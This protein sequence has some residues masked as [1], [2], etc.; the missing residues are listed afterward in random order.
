MYWFQVLKVDSNVTCN[1]SE[2]PEGQNY[3]S[4]IQYTCNKKRALKY[5]LYLVLMSRTIIMVHS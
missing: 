4:T 2:A 1:V 3:M 5:Q